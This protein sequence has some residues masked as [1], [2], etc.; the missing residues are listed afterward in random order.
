MMTDD[1]MTAFRLK[2]KSDPVYAAAYKSKDC[3]ELARLASIGRVKTVTIPIAIAQEYLQ[4]TGTWWAIEAAS[5]TSVSAKA[6][7]DVASAR[8][9]NI[10]TQLPLVITSFENI[11]SANIISQEIADGFFALGVA[12]D[13]VTQREAAIALYLDNGDEI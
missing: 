12:P 10:D 6:I 3:H 1:E 7:I 5:N 11:V 4:R 2:A 9:S 13:P 8:Y